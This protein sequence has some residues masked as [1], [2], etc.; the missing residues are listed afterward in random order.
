MFPMKKPIRLLAMV[1]Q[2]GDGRK[3]VSRFF[4]DN[5]RRL[6]KGCARLVGATPLSPLRKERR[7]EAGFT[8]SSVGVRAPTVTRNKELRGEERMQEAVPNPVK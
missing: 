3:K 7:P 4:R 8:S 2:I 6:G 5:P 1:F